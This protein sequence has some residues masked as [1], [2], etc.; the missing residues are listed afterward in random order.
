MKLKTTRVMLLLLLVIIAS[1]SA[2]A[3][4]KEG[5]YEGTGYSINYPAGWE[6][7]QGTG[8]IDSYA[9]S[10]LEGANDKFQEN[11]NILLET[12]P[13]GMSVQEYIT[14]A[15]EA[16]K[17]GMKG[18]NVISRKKITVD[19]QPGELMVYEHTYNGIKLNAGQAIVIKNG[20]VYII[21]LSALNET[22]GTYA[23][24]LDAALK[25]MKLK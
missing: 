6:V 20:N 2:S 25:S 24:Y 21:T 11:I 5:T 22:Y 23:P 13:Q 19:G 3:I 1:L 17:Q 12:L 7:K 15:I 18:L 8:G 16:A 14:G 4:A 10:P 9:L